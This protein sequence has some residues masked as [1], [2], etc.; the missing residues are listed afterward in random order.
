M[1]GSVAA[2]E[3]GFMQ[4]EI[5]RSA[6]E[7]QRSIETGDKIIVGVN[8]FTIDKEEP[9]PPFKIDD[10]IR[11]LQIEKLNDLKNRRDN[12]AVAKSLENI[13]NAAKNGTNLMP[14]V[15]EAVENKCTLGEIADVLR[16]EFGEY[17]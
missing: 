2:I 7:Y 17:R 14:L 8:K 5:A 15:I 12:N 4:D 10:S 13:A 11:E 16:K 3:Q 1:G 9:V 6:Y